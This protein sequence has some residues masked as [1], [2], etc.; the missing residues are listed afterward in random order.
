MSK[1][2]SGM[3]R[4]PHE[5]YPTPAWVVAEGL[6]PH[7]PVDG[8]RVL[9]PCCGPGQMARTLIACGAIVAAT[10][11]RRYRSKFFVEHA[12]VVDFLRPG[13][14]ETAR[15]NVDAIIANPPY[16]ASGRTAEAFIRRSLELLVDTMAGGLKCAAFLLPIDFDAALTRA[17]LF[18]DCP[19]FFGMI[20]LRRRIEWFKPPPGS[21]GPS[22][23]HAWFVWTAHERAPGVL[24]VKLYAPV[25]PRILK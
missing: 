3:A 16:G 11:K 20:T 9:D 18:E 15:S 4:K 12:A 1:R 10:D 22:G 13:A 24:P 19:M 5:L 17:S 2:N 6:V 8:L 21:S 14:W 25:A 23:N 7:F